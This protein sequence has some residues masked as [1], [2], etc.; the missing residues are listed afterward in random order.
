MKPEKEQLGKPLVSP[1]LQRAFEVVHKKGPEEAI[2]WV[3]RWHEKF[4]DKK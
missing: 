2:D 1:A 3:Q 4:G